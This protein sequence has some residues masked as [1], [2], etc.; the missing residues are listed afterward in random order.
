MD[1]AMIVKALRGIGLG[2]GAAACVAAIAAA[3]PAEK[4]DA[5]GETAAGARHVAIAE[6]MAGTDMKAPLLL[7]KPAGDAGAANAGV[8][9]IRQ[10]KDD[11]LK[12]VQVFDNLYY[13][14]TQTLG[15][16]ILKTS[17]GIVMFDSGTTV[18]VARDR[19]EPA[20]KGFGLDPR[21]IKYIVIT[22]GHADHFGGGSYWKEKYGTHLLATAADWHIME[23]APR[24]LP[25]LKNIPAPARDMVIADGQKLKLG[26]TILTL[27][28]TPGHTPGTASAIVPVR[29]KG[30]PVILTLLGGTNMAQVR[31]A[32]NRVGGLLNGERSMRRLAAISKQYGS[33]GLLNTHTYADGGLEHLEF[34]RN[35]GSSAPNPFVIGNANV[36]RYFNIMHECIEAGLSR[37]EVIDWVSRPY[38]ETGSAK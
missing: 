11:F 3:A 26:D 14:G 1:V 21:D 20:I 33:V 4:T 18:A 13:V 9:L 22:H 30:K 8:Q 12:P 2:I 37:P 36:I 5:N 27:F 24:D 16:Y 23:T 25:E 31:H 38:P 35:G 19:I 10:H 28:V 17:D 29:D 32:N 15:V 6:K 7:C 34:L